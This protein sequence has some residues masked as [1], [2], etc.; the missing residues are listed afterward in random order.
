M[1]RGFHPRAV[2]VN[3][4]HPQGDMEEPMPM[5]GPDGVPDFR[6]QRAIL[7]DAVRGDQDEP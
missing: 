4:I 1:N 2:F 3:N 5:M 7:N 6:M